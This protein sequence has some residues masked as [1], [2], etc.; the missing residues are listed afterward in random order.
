MYVATSATGCR[1]R[2]LIMMMMIVG[3]HILEFVYDYIMSPSHSFT[4]HDYSIL[5]SVHCTTYTICDILRLVNPANGKITIY[6]DMQ[7]FVVE[8]SQGHTIIFIQIVCLR[9]F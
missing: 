4:T 7:Y 3:F 6:N 8:M 2:L 9:F 5:S 1:G